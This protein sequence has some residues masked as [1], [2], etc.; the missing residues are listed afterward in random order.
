MGGPLTPLPRAFYDRPVLEVARDLL[1][2]I[3]A[4]GGV[5]V[6]LTEVEGYAGETDPGSH[7]FRGPG[8]R[9][10]TMYGPPGHV[11]VYFTYGMHWCMNLVCGPVGTARAV[12]LRAGEVVSGVPLA[13]AR[14]PR[15]GVRDLARGPARLTRVLD[16]DGTLDGTDVT[17]WPG[18]LAVLRG[19]PV[20]DPLVR[21]GPRV[22]LSAAAER[23]W[24]LW[25]DGE[26][27][28]SAYHPAVPRRRPRTGLTGSSS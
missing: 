25:V 5:A 7:A 21:A 20:P 17:R 16:V 15:T 9:N 6:R 19:A 22:G 28:V 27:T 24:R 10:A 26:P 23:P 13:Q 11:Y 12:L 8:R 2:M 4:R 14:R 1:G 18:P 3:V